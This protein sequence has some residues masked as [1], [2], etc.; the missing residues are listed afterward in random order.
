MGNSDKIEKI[1]GGGLALLLAVTVSTFLMPLG[2]VGVSAAGEPENRAAY[3]EQKAVDFI[4]KSMKTKGCLILH[5]L[6]PDTSRK[7]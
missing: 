3:P 7:V 6:C 5:R 4:L 2:T 1:A